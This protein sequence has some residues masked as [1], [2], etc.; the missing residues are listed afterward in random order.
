MLSYIIRRLLAVVPLVLVVSVLCFGLMHAI[1]GGP[2]ATLAENPKSS[3]QDLARIRA[4]FGLDRPVAVQYAHWLERVVLHGDLGRSY[5]T[6]EPIVSM[7]ARRL[8]ATIELMGSAFMLALLVGLSGGVLSALKAHTRWDV[9]L[10]FTALAVI[11]IP[12]FWSGLMSITLFSAKWQL[13]PS[14]G[15]RS[16]GEPF[17]VIDHLR[18][19]I[20][21][22][23]VL[24]LFFIASWS[25]YTR[26]GLIEAL[27]QEYIRVAKAKGLSEAKVV[28]VHALRN[29]LIPVVTVITLNLSLLFTGAVITEAIFAWPGMGRLFY[30]GL[31]LLDYS[32]VMGI[33][34]VSSV[35]I[36]V[37]NLI[38]DVLY[39]F[40]D[41][42]IRYA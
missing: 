2:T 27:Q 5:V 24:S 36:A 8:P 39:G 6:G 16:L 18:H 42:R 10:T 7:I 25:R 32:R 28:V 35:F 40:L 37:L 33:V 30:D 3:P 17:S 15:T 1:P 34:C 13:L 21:P 31:V 41:P 23:A 14:A 20:L 11:S 9:Y 29:A 12:V 19:L 26:A 4:N 38:A 22:S